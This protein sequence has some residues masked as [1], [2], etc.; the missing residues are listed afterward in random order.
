M[1]KRKLTRRQ[2]WRVEKIQAERTERAKR[3]DAK[4]D[5]VLEGGDLGPEQRGMIISHYGRQVEVEATEGALAGTLVRCHMRTH[6]GQLVTGDQVIW[7]ASN[8]GGVVV[9]AE[10]RR[11]ELLRPNN[12]GDLKPVAANIDYIVIVFAVEP[13]A[14]ANLIDRYLVAAEASEIEPVL[15]L[16][17]ADLL[18][19][20]PSEHIERLIAQYESIGYKILQVSSR[21]EHSLAKLKQLLDQHT[22]VFV[23]Q[24]GVG[25]SSL[26]NTLLPGVDLKV[27]ELS[28]QTRKGR[29]TTTTARL[30]HFPD[31]GDLIDSPGIREFALWHITPAQV[32][33]GFTEFRPFIG[34][35][36]FRDCQ[37]EAEPG[38]A[39]LEAV[40][41]GEISESR[42]DS[43][44]Q[45]LYSLED[46][47]LRGN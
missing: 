43:Y 25:K 13:H 32:L 24:S 22:S 31:G 14:H 41:N 47:Q 7:R 28:E 42:F 1:A 40:D 18:E 44:K 16:N 8:D 34:T 19:T 26:I 38:C 6:L 23:G 33:E 39:L 46:N 5:E 27:G 35:C 4:L 10:P 29:H 36:R 2:A 45:I 20:N 9:A 3:R 15:L 21:D 37:H 17:K 30:F 11:S 12:F